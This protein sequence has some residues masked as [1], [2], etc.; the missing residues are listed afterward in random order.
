MGVA[1][2]TARSEP[3]PEI[4]ILGEPNEATIQ[5]WSKE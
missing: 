1:E 2:I 5:E 3:D 4:N